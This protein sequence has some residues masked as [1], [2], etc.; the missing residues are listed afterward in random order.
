[1]LA[2]PE[3]AHGAVVQ[4]FA[5]YFL[6]VVLR[7]PHAQPVVAKL[8][9]AGVDSFRYLLDHPLWYVHQLCASLEMQLAL[10]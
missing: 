9:S 8:R 7:S 6:D 3:A 10:A 5:L 4:W 2:N 1:M